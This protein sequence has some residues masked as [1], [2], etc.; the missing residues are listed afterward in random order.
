MGF[1]GNIVNNIN[2]SIT[3][4][5]QFQFDKV[6]SNKFLL[7]N[8]AEYDDVY[9]GRYVLIDYDKD[10]TETIP[11]VLKHNDKFYYYNEWEA[12]KND[13]PNQDENT[14]AN[15][16]S[17][18]DTYTINGYVYTYTPKENNNSDTITEDFPS[19]DNC[20]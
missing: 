2:G 5:V 18:I 13:N 19:Y 1:Y 15:K 17:P 8:T 10:I 20:S 3:P 6:V 14:I 7:D 16:L 9:L 4:N 11:R 12:I